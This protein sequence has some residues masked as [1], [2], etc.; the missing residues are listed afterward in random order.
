MADPIGALARAHQHQ[1]DDPQQ[2]RE[3]T[4]MGMWVFL[5]TEVM[6]F[7]GMFCAYTVYRSLYPHSF[8]SASATLSIF[9]GTLNT[10]IL[11]LSSL[12]MAMAVHS[13]QTGKRKQLIVYLIATMILGIAFLGLKADEWVEKFRLHHVPGPHFHFLGPAAAHTQVFFSL[14]FAMTGMHALH[15]VVG[16]GLMLY[17]LVQAWRGVFTETYHQPVVIC[18]LYWH[19]V[20]I[21]WIFLYPLFYLVG[22][23]GVVK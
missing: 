15:M 16:V 12:T 13:S 14:Y 2:Q 11:L 10:G 5:C 9:I 7:G 22:V 21:I 4:T 8:E 1:Y 3:T 19:F 6:F 23:Q 17:L 18:G 20:D